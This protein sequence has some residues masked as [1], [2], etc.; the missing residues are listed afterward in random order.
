MQ[1]KSRGIWEWQIVGLILFG[2]MALYSIFLWQEGFTESG[3]RLIIRWTAKIDVCCFCIAFGAMAFHQLIQ[4]SFSF[5]V[6]RN[7]KY[8]GISFAI[9]HLIHLA[10][11][12]ALQY[13]FHPVFEEVGGIALLGGGI[14]YF[15]IIS[16][17]LTSFERFSTLLSRKQWK[18]LHTFGGYWIMMLF[19][20]TYITRILTG[21][22]DYSFFLILILIILALRLWFAFRPKRT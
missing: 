14:A 10:S 2:S 1:E 22:Y 5:W 12:G 8:F 3:A 6:Y 20:I 15:F 4:N 19:A 9:L 18:R 17:L 13:Y 21:A 16:M 7:R 11:L